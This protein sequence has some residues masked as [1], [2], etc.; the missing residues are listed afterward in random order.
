M[1]AWTIS[2][3]KN[4]NLFSYGQK[5]WDCISFLL[6]KNFYHILNGSQHRN[7]AV[8]MFCL[9]IRLLDLPL[10]VMIRGYQDI[11]FIHT[12]PCFQWSDPNWQYKLLSKEIII[13]L[14]R[15][16]FHRHFLSHALSY[17][18][19]L[20]KSRSNHLKLFAGGQIITY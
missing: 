2:K 1:N 20:V 18:N 14:Q 8:A 17:E 16:D 9:T 15:F 19:F 12:Y 13:L 11:L 4:G 10:F 5:F 3:S 7:Y 6:S